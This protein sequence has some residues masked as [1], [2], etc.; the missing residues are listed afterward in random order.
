MKKSLILFCLMLQFW[1]LAADGYYSKHIGIDNGLSQSAITAMAYDSRGSFWIGTRF[2]LN[3]YRNGRLR[4]FLDDGTSRIE[5]TYIYL[6]HCDAQGDLWASTDKGLF[7]YDAHTDSFAMISE[8]TVTAAVDTDSGTWFGSHFGL[9]FYSGQTGRLEGEDTDIY[10]DYQQLFFHGGDLYA[11]DK[12]NG[13]VRYVDGTEEVVPFPELEGNTVMASALDGGILYLSLLNFGLIGYDLDERRVVFR[14]RGGEGGLPQEPLLALMVVED[15]LWMGFDGASVWIMDTGSRHLEPLRLQPAQSGGHIP[16]S[17]TSLYDDPHGNV[18]IGSVRF[19]IT[20]LKRSPIKSF[21]LTDADPAAENVIISLCSSV[22]GSIYLGTDGSGIWKY[23]QAGGLSFFSGNDGLKVTSIA[24]FD[25]RTLCIATYNRG[26]FLIDRASGGLRPFTLVDE[27]TNAIE[28]FSSNSPTIHRLADG[29]ILFL[30]VDAYIYSPLTRRFEVLTDESGGDGMELVVIGSAGN[31]TLYA[32]TGTGLFTINTESKTVNVLF[33]STVDSGSVNTAVYHGGLIWFGSNYGL[34]SFDPRSGNVRKVESGLFSRVSRLESNGSDILWIAANNSLFL[35]RN[36]VMEMTGE[37]RGV[38][39]NEIL[40]STCAPDGTVFL[41]GTAGLVEIGA[42]CFFSVDENKTLELQ[43]EASRSIRVP[44]NY[45]SLQI[46]VNLAGA[47]PF[48]RVLYR[49]SV[50]GASELT[51]ESF[52][53]SISLPALKPGRYN[54]KASYLKSDGTWSTPQSLSE[55]RVKQPWFAST[56][57]IMIYVLMSVLLIAFLIDWI[58]R[59]RINAL[60]AELR[61][62]D[63]VFTGKVE[64]FIDEHLADTQLSVADLANHMAMSRATLYYKMNSAFGKGVAEVIEEKRM[65][66]AEDLLSNSSFSV[67]D[68]SEKVGYSTSRYF[69]TR[70]KLLHDGLTPLKYRQLHR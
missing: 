57:M 33:R 52:E 16:L 5:G 39:A 32:Y 14:Q 49:Y 42:D 9:K 44:Y 68:I 31:G 54:V 25:D 38:P 8:S 30:A 55:L 34:F 29:R 22:D 56:G 11:L 63:A 36:G 35:S 10:S 2:G 66:K 7:R 43:D 64:A 24:D 19:G 15:K 26:F 23:T 21:S 70:F 3:E 1:S 41:G 27:K 53:Q 59:K 46:N 28:C 69:S 12:K 48:E 37:N 17:V 13:L 40:S 50:S 20:G 45:T 65:A 61:A 62:R 18:W 4:T 60:E 51:I 67:L 58:S 47:D 6:L